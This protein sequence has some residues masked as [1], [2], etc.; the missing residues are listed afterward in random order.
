M[1]KW[2]LDDAG[3]NY[4]VALDILG[5]EKQPFVNTMWEERRK[6]KPSEALVAYCEARIAALDDLQESLRSGDTELISQ[7]LDKNNK[8]FRS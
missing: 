4:E 3:I 7:I 1:P 5:Q 6:E 8:L 2:Q